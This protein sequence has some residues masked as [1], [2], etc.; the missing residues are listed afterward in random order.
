VGGSP[1]KL[2]SDFFCQ[3][4]FTH[5]MKRQKLLEQQIR[6]QQLLSYLK[7]LQAEIK[8]CQ[9]AIAEMQKSS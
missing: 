7:A 5:K 6:L 2:K 3:R 9:E 4:G 1:K 8:Q